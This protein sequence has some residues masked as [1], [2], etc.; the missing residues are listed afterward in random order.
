MKCLRR[1]LTVWVTGKRN[2][3]DGA[4]EKL[5]TYASHVI[6]ETF[7]VRPARFDVPIPRILNQACM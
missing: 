3:E 4:K 1:K 5:Y 6:V 7:K 2:D